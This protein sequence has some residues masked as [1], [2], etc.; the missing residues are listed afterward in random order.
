MQKGSVDVDMKITGKVVY[1][2]LEGGFWGIEDDTG[3]QFL[4]LNMPNQLKINGARVQVTARTSDQE[5]LFMWGEPI[6]I[7]SFHTLPRFR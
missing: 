2:S 6:E 4:V 1:Q 5:T 3:R 7:I